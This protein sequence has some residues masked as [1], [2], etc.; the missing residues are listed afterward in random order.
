MKKNIEALYI[1]IAVILFHIIYLV[2]SIILNHFVPGA[3]SF[4][5]IKK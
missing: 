5:W 3:F 1:P 4:G 2:G